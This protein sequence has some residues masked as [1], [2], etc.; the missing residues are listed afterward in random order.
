M[1]EICCLKDQ[2]SLVFGALKIGTNQQD[3]SNYLRIDSRKKDLWGRKLTLGNYLPTY[4]WR[5]HTLPV[6]HLR[7]DQWIQ[8][9]GCH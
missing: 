8:W 5:D 6:S 9:D 1:K 3:H 7:I 2:R 4:C